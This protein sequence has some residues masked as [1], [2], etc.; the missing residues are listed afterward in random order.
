[1]VSYCLSGMHGSVTAIHPSKHGQGSTLGSNTPAAMQLLRALDLSAHS[2]PPALYASSLGNSTQVGLMVCDTGSLHHVPA[3][4]RIDSRS[5]VR[6]AARTP[7]MI[8]P[9]FRWIQIY[10]CLHWCYIKT[11]TTP[12]R[13]S[14]EVTELRYLQILPRGLIIM[15]SSEP[16]LH[17][18]SF[19]GNGHQPCLQAEVAYPDPRGPK[20]PMPFNAGDSQRRSQVAQSPSLHTLVPPSS[21]V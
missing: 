17:F 6:K 16:Q 10:T 2:G 19:H 1:M 18:V 13:S 8:N 5:P 11:T 3:S 12:C 14:L 4:P 9:T 20:R 21:T 7:R 15:T